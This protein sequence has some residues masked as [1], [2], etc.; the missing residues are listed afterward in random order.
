M[1][2]LQMLAAGSSC[3]W[4]WGKGLSS[5]QTT[6]GVSVNGDSAAGFHDGVMFKISVCKHSWSLARCWAKCSLFSGWVEKLCAKMDF[7]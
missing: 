6:A 4:A 1:N 7:G 3:G 5:H 2:D